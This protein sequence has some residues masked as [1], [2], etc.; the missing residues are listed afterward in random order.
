MFEIIRREASCTSCLKGKLTQHL[1]FLCPNQVFASR[2]NSFTTDI[3]TVSR[4]PTDNAR[5]SHKKERLTLW[6][7]RRVVFVF[8]ESENGNRKHH[9]VPGRR[10]LV[11]QEKISKGTGF[12]AVLLW[13]LQL[14]LEYE[15]CQGR[16]GSDPTKTFPK[17]CWKYNCPNSSTSH[18]SALWYP[19]EASEVGLVESQA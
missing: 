4:K 19:S 15:A 2:L 18:S 14:Q 3:R 9:R 13:L 8:S 12:G 16:G 1:S 6:N 10:E 7:L 17:E 5:P 11:H